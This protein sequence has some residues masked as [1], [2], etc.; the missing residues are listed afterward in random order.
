MEDRHTDKAAATQNDARKEIV[1]RERDAAFINRALDKAGLSPTDFRVFC[2]VAS[3]GVC[4]E[5]AENMA[6]ICRI[7]RDTVFQA[8]K[9]LEER[10]MVIRKHRHKPTSEITVTK[11]S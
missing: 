6:K 9:R 4:F 11:P 8:L 2:H 5:K 10:G 3:R 1:S 7:K